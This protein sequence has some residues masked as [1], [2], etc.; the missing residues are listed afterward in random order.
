VLRLVRRVPTPAA[1]PVTVLG[2]DDWA[3]RRGS[4]YGTILVNLRTHRVIDLLPDRTAATFAAW[5]AGHPEV[6]V[7][8]RDR[9][10]AYAEGARLGAPQAIQVADR[11]HLLKNVTD[12]LMHY[13]TRKQPAW[14]KAATSPR[15]DGLPVGD[16]LPEAETPPVLT[17]TARRSQ[18][19]RSR[20]RTRYD[21]V[22]ALHEQGYSA[23]AIATLA[24]L[25]RGTVR[26]YLRA[27]R[28][29]ERQLPS[30]RPT[31]LTPY[32]GYL[33]DRWA[34]GCHNATQLWHELRGQGYAGGRARV[35]EYVRGWRILP[36]PPHYRQSTVG[37]LRATSSYG[38]RQTGWLLLRPADTLTTAESAYLTH[39][40]HAC[41]EVALMEALVEEFAAVLR[42]RDVPGLYDWLHGVTLSGIPE[43]R[44]VACSMW[45]DRSAV[46]AAVATDWS[47]GH[48][49][50]QVNRLKV[51]KRITYGRCNFDLLRQI[52]LHTPGPTAKSIIRSA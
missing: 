37:T 42:T 35:A 45:L 10:G 36:P 20:R 7:I 21:E 25:S 13:L 15:S 30:P 12:A 14:R 34:V 6:Q 44:G 38:P 52:V 27:D 41:P 8:S 47:N 43:L 19:A 16:Y 48:V 29:P 1:G 23:R 17:R 2:V 24:H 39:L 9:G 51:T 40:Y 26:T 50:G 5:L 33:Q 28:F 46:E 32:A 18:E 22:M 49:E 4:T 31:I 11:F 3:K